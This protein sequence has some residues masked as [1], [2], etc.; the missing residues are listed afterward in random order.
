MK[1]IILDPGHG[2]PDSGATGF[3]LKEA[4][5]ALQ[6]AEMVGDYF[7]KYEVVVTFTRNRNTSSSYPGPPEGLYKRINYANSKSADLFLSLHCNSG[8][9]SGFESYIAKG[10]PAKTQRIQKAINESVLGYLKGYGIDPHGNAA[11]NDTQGA[12][13]RIA[14]LRD[15]RMSAVLLECLF[16]DNPRENKLLRDKRFLDGLA[17][18]IVK[19]VAVAFGLKEKVDRPKPMY[20]VTVDGEVIYDTAYEE[21]IVGIVLEATGKQ[22]EVILLKKL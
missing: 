20:R 6:L 5:V 14:V 10:A 7:G 3:G 1:T 15:T 18:A 2:G 22:A 13:S 19:G 12:H 21:K 8:G 17:G 16:I 4:D 11:K 9:G